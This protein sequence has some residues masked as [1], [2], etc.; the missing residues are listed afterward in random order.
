MGVLAL[1][2]ACSVALGGE[3]ATVYVNANIYTMDAARPRA[4]AMAVCSWASNCRMLITGP[5]LGITPIWD[6][7]MLCTGVM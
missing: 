1:L 4:E 7:F 5:P 6:T 3:P 2:A